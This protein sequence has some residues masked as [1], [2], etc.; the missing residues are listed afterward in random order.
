VEVGEKIEMNHFYVNGGKCGTKLKIYVCE[1]SI[2][3][4]HKNSEV[5]SLRLVLHIKT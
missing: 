1:V 4:L 2:L 5:V 3:L